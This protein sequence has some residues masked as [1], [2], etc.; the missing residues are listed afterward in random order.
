MR[1][2]R[3][4]FFSRPRLGVTAGALP[5]PLGDEGRPGEELV[6]AVAAA[7]GE[8]E[9][10]EGEE[11]K[12]RGVLRRTILHTVMGLCHDEVTPQ[13]LRP[14]LQLL[15]ASGPAR[16][17]G[18]AVVAE[19]VLQ[20]LLYWL[21]QDP[22]PKGLLESIRALFPSPQAFVAFIVLAAVNRGS[23]APDALRATGLRVLVAYLMRLDSAPPPSSS[24]SALL[25]PTTA[26]SSS[27]GTSSGITGGGSAVALVPAS[28]TL[29]ASSTAASS[30]VLGAWDEGGGGGG[31]AGFSTSTSK[32][33]LPTSR[34]ASLSMANTYV[35][36][37]YLSICLYVHIS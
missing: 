13:E 26:S 36:V 1:M 12:D 3:H 9:E 23:P 27:G 11:D 33:A 29:T 6:A 28:P 7:G 20:V 32:L 18:E 37:Y 5:A 30:P 16:G 15:A 10:E 24:T 35:Y 34:T 2:Y 8:G 4:H 31:G 17:A 25:L 21:Q 14:L 19:E 22:A